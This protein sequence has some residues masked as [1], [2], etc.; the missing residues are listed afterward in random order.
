MSYRNVS[1]KWK[2]IRF[3]DW[4]QTGKSG[5]KYAILNMKIIKL[6]GRTATDSRTGT[7]KAKNKTKES[8]RKWRITYICK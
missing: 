5:R 8:Q 6:G 7:S 3:T 2:K 4:Y 1:R